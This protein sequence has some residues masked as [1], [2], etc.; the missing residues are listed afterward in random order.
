ML[1]AGISLQ[2][3]RVD[4]KAVKELVARVNTKPTRDRK[5]RLFPKPQTSYQ[6]V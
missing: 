4:G 2:D 3:S 6:I 5:V 1:G